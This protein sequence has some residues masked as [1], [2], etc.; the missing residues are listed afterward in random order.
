MNYSIDTGIKPYEVKME[1]ELRG[2]IRVTKANIQPAAFTLAKAFQD[3]PL[4]VFFNPYAPT[5]LQKQTKAFQSAV[6][7]GIEHGEVYTVSEK[8]EGIAIWFLSSGKLPL[9]KRRISLRQLFTTLLADKEQMRRVH[10]FSD[11]ADEVRRRLVPGR[12]WYLQILGVD[13]AYQG[14]ELA[15]RLLKP[16]LAMAD[17]QG[18]PCF[19]ET[20]ARKNIALYEHFGFRVAEEGVIPGSGVPSW[21]MVRDAKV[22]K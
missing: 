16:M 22:L 19:L 4:I 5:R 14:K 12:H 3:Y 18:L 6:R 20:Q 15:S 9:F 13:P 8:L 1:D 17:K 2:L 7:Y 10:A 11:Y 21:A